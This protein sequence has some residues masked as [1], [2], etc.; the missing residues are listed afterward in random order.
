M[1]DELEVLTAIRDVLFL[2]A[3][4]TYGSA[5]HVRLSKR[6]KRRGWSIVM[7]CI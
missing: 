4:T 3:G 5:K 6:Y 2:E 1:R 7:V